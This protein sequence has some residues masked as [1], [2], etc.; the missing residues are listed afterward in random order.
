MWNDFNSKVKKEVIS[1]NLQS[2]SKSIEKP[3]Y[4][5]HITLPLKEMLDLKGYLEKKRLEKRREKYK[6]E[7]P[8]ENSIRN[9]D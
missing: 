2:G 4:V 3:K 1:N 7:T 6:S 5:A 8:E 9:D